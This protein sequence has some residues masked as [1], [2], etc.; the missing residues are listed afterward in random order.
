MPV[1]MPITRW[2]A[3]IT[4]AVLLVEPPAVRAADDSVEDGPAKAADRGQEVGNL[5]DLGQNF[6]ANVFEQAGGGWTLRGGGLRVR[7]PSPTGDD[8]S[9]PPSSPT[10]AR[11]RR[12]G[13]ARL[14]Q[15]DRL[16][17]LSDRQRL[18]LRLAIESDLRRLAEQIDVERGKYVGVAVN[19]GGPEGQKT[20]QQFQEDVQRCRRLLRALFNDDSLFAATLAS[21]LDAGQ[22]ERLAAETRARRSFRWKAMVAAA[23]LRIDDAI[24]LDEKQHDTIERLLVAREPPLRADDADRQPNPHAEQM[25]VYLTLASVDQKTL[26]AAVSDRQWLALSTLMNQGRAMQSW[27]EEQGLL[28]KSGR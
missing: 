14:E 7:R 20:W 19:M 27:L 8:G 17:G 10:L 25:L 5:I 12:L 21:T 28:E 18:A 6:D 4:L 15:I 3:A 13:A 2:L 26:Q 9:Q 11:G 22:L 23:M 16:C 24:G 1:R